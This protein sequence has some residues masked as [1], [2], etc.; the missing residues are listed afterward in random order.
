MFS[1]PTPA[2]ENET[3]ELKRRSSRWEVRRLSREWDS[4]GQRT[5]VFPYVLAACNLTPQE[6]SLALSNLSFVSTFH[7]S[8]TLSFLFSLLFCKPTP[9]DELTGSGLM[10]QP[11]TGIRRAGGFWKWA[12]DTTRGEGAGHG[13][14]SRWTKREL[15]GWGG[16]ACR[17]MSELR[18]NEPAKEHSQFPQAIVLRG[19]YQILWLDH[20]QWCCSA[21]CSI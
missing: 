18:E 4:W 16:Q 1:I 20:I 6:P 7:L 12:W 17:R 8:H 9:V 14:A 5:F 11:R 15:W 2:G 10:F 21:T 3:P 19:T 13:V